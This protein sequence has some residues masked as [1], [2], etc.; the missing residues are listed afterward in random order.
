MGEFKKKYVHCRHCNR[1]SE[2]HEEKRSDVNIA[3]H[4]LEDCRSGLMDVA[5]VVTTDSDITPAFEMCRRIYPHVELVTVAPPGR[6][7]C[8]ALRALANRSSSVSRI[9]VESCLMP[10]QITLANGEIIRRPSEYDPA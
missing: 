6:Q 8:K 4:L 7:P 1:S 3:L 2:H 10:N 9:Q 5:Y